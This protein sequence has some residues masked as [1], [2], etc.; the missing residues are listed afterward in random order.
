M[1]PLSRGGLVRANEGSRVADV[2][3][4]REGGRK[5]RAVTGRDGRRTTL[6][7]HATRMVLAVRA[8]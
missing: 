2:A 8:L 6:R 3:N 4:T 5:G 1:H 7:V